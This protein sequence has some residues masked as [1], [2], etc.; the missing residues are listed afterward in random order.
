MKAR[1]F[2]AAGLVLGLCACS[3]KPGTRMDAGGT[4]VMIVASD[5]GFTISDTLH[6]GLNHLVYEN[7]GRNIHECQFIHLPTGMSAADYVAQVKSGIPF[8]AGAKD[9]AGPGLLS[10]GERVEM[11]S[12]LEAGTYMIGCWMGKHMT[13]TKPVTFVVHGAPAQPVQPP[14]E[15]VTVRMVDF[16]FELDGALKRGEQVIRYETV[17]PSMHEA[18]IIKLGDGRTVQDVA[19]WFKHHQ[20]DPLPGT[21]AGGCM[22]SHDITRVT[23][24]KRSFAPGRYVFWC[25][26]PMIQ[27]DAPKDTTVK[28]VSH[29][30]A[31]MIKEFTVD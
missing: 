16:R 7:H 24:V 12:P 28:A 27:S 4:P 3:K 17:G 20:R 2:L 14:H 25:D 8:P 26:M 21:I 11:W 5:S 29:A 1:W 23:W 9:C 6:T 15:D 18:D 19:A 13:E 10:P 30:D 31:G 22:D